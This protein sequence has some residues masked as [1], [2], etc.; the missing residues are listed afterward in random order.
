M[1]DTKKI[2]VP[3]S[4]RAMTHILIALQ[5]YEMRLREDEDEPGPSMDDA[6][7][8]RWLRKELEKYENESAG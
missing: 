3:L 8:V 6:M 7:F 4:Q 2:E 5:E 1:N